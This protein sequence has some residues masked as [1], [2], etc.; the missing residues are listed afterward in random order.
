MLYNILRIG[1]NMK[2][3]KEEEKFI[4][5]AMIVGL[6]TFGGL[7][8]IFHKTSDLTWYVEYVIAIGLALGS[9]IGYLAGAFV[10][11]LARKNKKVAAAKKR[12]A[13]KKTTKKKVASKKT[14]SKK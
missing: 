7:A 3:K 11:N 2:L 12:A 1:V 8:Y 5:L 6:V 9:A 10:V 4:A 14:S 13:S